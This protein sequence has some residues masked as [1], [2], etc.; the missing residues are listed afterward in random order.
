VPVDH[1]IIGIVDAHHV[2]PDAPDTP[3]GAREGA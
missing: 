1:T 3:G 2:I